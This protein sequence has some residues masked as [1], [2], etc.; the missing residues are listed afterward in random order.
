MGLPEKRSGSLK[1]LHRVRL[2]L[3]EYGRAELLNDAQHC[4][5]ARHDVAR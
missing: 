1:S 5:D 4:L 2:V 3:T